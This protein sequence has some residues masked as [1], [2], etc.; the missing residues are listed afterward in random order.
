M[1]RAAPL[2]RQAGHGPTGKETL[3][4]AFEEPTEA[5]AEGFSRRQLFLRVG[6]G[7]AGVTLASLC[8]DA[9]PPPAAA[10]GS[11]ISLRD[12]LR[13]ISIKGCDPSHGIRV[14]LP[15][16]HPVI[17]LRAVARR[18]AGSVVDFCQPVQ[19]AIQQTDVA[20]GGVTVNLTGRNF[21]GGGMAAIQYRSASRAADNR[22]FSVQARP[23]GTFAQVIKLGCSAPG[24]VSY[25]L[26]AIDMASGRSA[27]AAG[28]YVCPQLPSIT[29]SQKGSVFTVKGTGFLHNHTVAVRV[30]NETTV[31][32]GYFDTSSDA[33][34]AID[35]GINIPC[36]PS[37]LLVF[38]ATDNRTVP[39]SQDHTGLLWSNPVTLTCQ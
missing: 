22:D 12:L 30:V 13:R 29:V 1:V 6:G 39:S 7:L 31:V 21:A 37:V 24:P 23:D 38:T 9:G 16:D 27:D 3:M 10:A 26:R 25:T 11:P 32:D 14:A 36:T 28:S 15:N 4:S 17:S 18:Y 33:A 34:G 19:I 8:C 20:G 5:R 35:F 2:V